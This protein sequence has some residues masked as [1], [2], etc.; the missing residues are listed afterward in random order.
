VPAATSPPSY[1]PTETPTFGSTN[2]PTNQPSK[3]SFVTLNAVLTFNLPLSEPITD[4]SVIDSFEDTVEVFLEQKMSGLDGLIITNFNVTVVSQEV[5]FGS[6]ENMR[7]EESAT[8]E[9]LIV[10][11]TL[12]AVG[13]PTPLA[14]IYPFQAKAHIVMSENSQELYQELHTSTL[15]QL[16]DPPPTENTRNVELSNA[17]DDKLKTIALGSS[18][19][20][21]LVLVSLLAVLIV[22]RRHENARSSDANDDDD[23]PTKY[24]SAIDKSD[25]EISSIGGSLLSTGQV[26]TNYPQNIPHYNQ[27]EQVDTSNWSLTDDAFPAQPREAA[28]QGKSIKPHHVTAKNDIDETSSC[29]RSLK[30]DAF[31]SIDETK[32]AADSNKNNADDKIATSTSQ[33]DEEPDPTLTRLYDKAML[34][35][36][37][38][39]YEGSTRIVPQAAKPSQGFKM[40]S[41]FADNTLEDNQGLTA[42]RILQDQYRST[43]TPKATN[44]SKARIYEVT[45][46]AGPLGIIIDSNDKGPF[47]HEIKSKSPLFGL[48]EKGDWIESIDGWNCKEKHASDVARWI[49]IKRNPG[50]QVLVM[51]GRALNNAADDDE[52]SV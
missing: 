4:K 39:S 15:K 7:L 17:D 11:T 2:A 52:G 34:E 26:S 51:K 24:A 40:F 49:K 13:A 47:V 42:K 12:A 37:E 8:N 28:G 29:A 25:D 21:V 36:D 33:D 16:L 10:T 48:V 43:R 35:E 41:C 32:T 46:P 9:Y 5:K 19:A 31:V 3:P 27:E 14:S 22:H 38:D 30:K 20:G 18:V 50:Q 6:T 1:F 23:P 45:V 44:T